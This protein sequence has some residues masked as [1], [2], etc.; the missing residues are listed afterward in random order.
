MQGSE[1][2]QTDP[3]MALERPGAFPGAED[4]GLP[5]FLL[6]IEVSVS[7]Q[8]Q[9]VM[10]LEGFLDFQGV[11][12]DQDMPAGP[13]HLEGRVVEKHAMTSCDSVEMRSLPMVVIAENAVDGQLQG[14]EGLQDLGLGDVAGMHH[15]ID[16]MALEDF[17][18]SSDTS[19]VVM[20]ISDHA[21][22]HGIGFA[23]SRSIGLC[24]RAPSVS[25]SV[26]VRRLR[27]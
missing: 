17:H 4:Q 18:D 2:D 23:L 26:F 10:G 24:L 15:P 16:R 7:M 14:R 9:S 27:G 25:R 21:D 19:Q 5:E 13:M 22:H 20:S 1:I 12:G 8:R 6:P 3:I 11:V